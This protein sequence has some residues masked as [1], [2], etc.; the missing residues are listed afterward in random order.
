MELAVS[1]L[2]HCRVKLELRGHTW[3]VIHP[4]NNTLS[5]YLKKRGG[6]YYA[7][8]SYASKKEDQNEGKA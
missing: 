7:E 8:Y 1:R 6:T 3:M 5:D 4:I 2:T